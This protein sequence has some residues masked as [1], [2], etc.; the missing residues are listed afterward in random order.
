LNQ[1][2]SHR[3]A[4]GSTDTSA[5][6]PTNTGSADG[7][8]AEPMLVLAFCARGRGVGLQ[9]RIPAGPEGLVLGRGRGIEPFHQPLLDP[10]MSERHAVVRLEGGQAVVSDLGSA[11]GTF[12][13]GERLRSQL[14]LTPGDV[15]RLG[16]TLLVYAPGTQLA[17]VAEEEL[18]GAGSAMA[19]VRKS[20]DAIAPRKHTVVITGETGTGKEVVARILHQRSGRKGPFLAI[21]C[22]AFTEGLLAS[23]LFGHVRGAFTGALSDSPGLLRA[24]AGGTVLLDE[25]ADM[26]L[27]LQANLL[28]VLEERE[29]RPVG[30]A[31]AVS[32]DVRIIATSNR[33]LSALVR[34]GTFRADLFA[35]LSQ[36]TIR[37]PRL[38][39]RREDIP[40]LITSLLE[41]CDGAGRELTPDLAEA[42]LLHEW[43]LNVRGLFNVLSVA[44]I[45]GPAKGP[46]GL[47]HDVRTALDVTRSL[48][49]AAEDEAALAQ[50]QA[51][52]DREALALLLTQFQGRVAALGRHLGYSRPKMYRLLE[53]HGLE[54]APF[55]AARQVNAKGPGEGQELE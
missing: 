52:P 39:D 48:R 23:E 28:R 1:A 45:A 20:I 21:N 29:V 35:R 8:K 16:D 25:M 12:L 44:V 54:P 41:R 19:A 55:R 50:P 38:A 42:L 3:T 9:C 31:Q 7:A 53:L 47:V 14:P 37:M 30:A 46:L 15:L 34:E 40:S 6:A 49:P 33:E 43:P 36:W 24:A 27:S 4:N 2:T 11:R 18:V 22:A 10:R 5:N 32:I 51:A 17:A 26:P 13:N